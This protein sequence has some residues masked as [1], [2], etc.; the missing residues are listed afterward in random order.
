MVQILLPQWK[1]QFLDRHWILGIHLFHL[2]H[3]Q[4]QES[5]WLGATGAASADCKGSVI[6][7]TGDV[8][9]NQRDRT[10]ESELGSPVGVTNWALSNFPFLS[11]CLQW[12]PSASRQTGQRQYQVKDCLSTYKYL[13]FGLLVHQVWNIY[14]LALQK[15]FADPCSRSDFLK[16]N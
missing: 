8:G 5:S 11:S 7:H 14:C 3:G 2:P 15:S 6:Y 10:C 13:Q 9:E 16:D 4:Q 12:Q 1:I